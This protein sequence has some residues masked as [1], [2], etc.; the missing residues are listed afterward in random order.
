GGL[1]L[2]LHGDDRVRRGGGVL[3]VADVVVS[4]AVEAV[5]VAG[6][7]GEGQR[8][9]QRVAQG[10]DKR[11][12][13]TGDVDVEAGE[14]GGGGLGLG[15]PADGE[16]RIERGGGQ[17][18]DLAGR[19]GGIERVVDQRRVDRVV[20]VE[21][22]AGAVRDKGARGQ[23]GLRG[24]AIADRSLTAARGVVGVEQADE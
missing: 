3:D 21:D 24:D 17:G 1:R 15:G 11:A 12:V 6:F 14:A 10:R 22:D 13:L 7:S 8:R 4:D 18:L 16:G 23:S 5:S 20:V 9:Q 2:G 19:R